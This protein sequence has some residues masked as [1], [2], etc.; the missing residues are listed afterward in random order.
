MREDQLQVL[1]RRGIIVPAYAEYIQEEWRDNPR[2]AMDAQPSLITVQN[3]GIP[4]YLANLVDPKVIRVLTTPMKAADIFS[5]TKKGTWTTITTQFPVVESTGHV[6]SYGDYSADGGVGSNY[7]WVPRQSYHFQTV[8]QYGDRE[9]E[10]FGLAQINYVSD[11]NYSSAL[12]IAK[13]QNLTYF[14]GVDIPNNF[15]ALNDPSLIAPIVPATKVAG[16]TGWANALAI[17]IFNDIMALFVQLQTQLGGLIDRDTPMTLS[18]SPIV[19]PNMGRVTEYTLA[20]VR[21]AIKDNW[22]NLKIVTAPE[23]NTTAG[24]L[25]Q[26]IVDDVDGDKTAYCAFTEKM[27]AGRVVPYLSHFAQKK[28]AG[29]WGTVI[30][31]PI[32]IASMLGL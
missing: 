1:E 11:L 23:Y 10:M 15:G 18:L 25:A 16:G 19:E 21:A 29:T 28:S 14:Y 31:R 27:R 24:E 17:E 6:A 4:A 9:T 8:T 20:P 12:L 30:R 26:L 32:A 5:E 3:I 13:F 22:K 2:L 7:N